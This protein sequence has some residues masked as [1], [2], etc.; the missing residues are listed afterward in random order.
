MP[1]NLTKLT[2]RSLLRILAASGISAVTA[3]KVF[4][5]GGVWNSIGAIEWAPLAGPGI[6]V[7]II[8]HP[9][10]PLDD[11]TLAELRKLMLGDRQFWNSNLRVTL[12]ARAT[13]SREREVV[14]KTI[15]QMT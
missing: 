6:D 4:A 10:V 13:G 14:L 2:R 15:Y 12:L 7:A 5:T 8:V 9:D 3:G 11:V 1:A